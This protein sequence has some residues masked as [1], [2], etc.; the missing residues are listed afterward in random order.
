MASLQTQGDAGTA[1]PA[2][3][4]EARDRARAQPFCFLLFYLLTEAKVLSV[5]IQ[6]PMPAPCPVSEPSP[7]TQGCL[8][9]VLLCSL[10]W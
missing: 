5:Q 3:G 6:R 1:D 9:L 10:V 4:T 7:N 2:P 8:R